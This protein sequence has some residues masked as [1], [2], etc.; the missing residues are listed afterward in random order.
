MSAYSWQVR[1]LLRSADFL[2][3]LLMPGDIYRVGKDEITRKE[4]AERV[5]D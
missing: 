2:Q 1:G 3:L 5:A 4:Q